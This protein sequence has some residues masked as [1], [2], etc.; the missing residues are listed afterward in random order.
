M[1]EPVPVFTKETVLQ[2]Y[3]CSLCHWIIIYGTCVYC[4]TG[5]VTM[6]FRRESLGETFISSW[7][8]RIPWICVQ[9]CRS[10]TQE[11]VKWCVLYVVQCVGDSKFCTFGLEVNI[12]TKIPYYTRFEVCRLNASVKTVVLDKYT[13]SDRHRRYDYPTQT[14]LVFN[15]TLNGL[16]LSQEVDLTSRVPWV[17]KIVLRSSSWD[18]TS[19][20][21]SVSRRSRVWPWCTE[22]ILLFLK[23]VHCSRVRTAKGTI[24]ELPV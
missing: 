19:K 2:H 8:L 6:F 21:W 1:Y 17:E 5:D 15:R 20:W 11:W 10:F 14:V 4:V 9:G 16:P 24:K 7:V 3:Y 13:T 23:W 12:G 18:T 22:G